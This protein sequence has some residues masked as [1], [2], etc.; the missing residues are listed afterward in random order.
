MNW[1]V[2]IRTPWTLSSEEVWDKTH[3]IGGRLFKVCGVLA[4]GGVLV[5]GW[6]A[7]LLTVAPVMAAVMYLFYYSYVEY[8]KRA[9]DVSCPGDVS[10]P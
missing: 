9:Q 2:G 5:G 6:M 10:P 4:L 7:L 8:R 3:E 1:F